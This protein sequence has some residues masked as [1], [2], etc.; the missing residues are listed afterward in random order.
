MSNEINYQA[1]ELSIEELDVVAGGA[2][3][4]QLLVKDFDASFEQASVKD[5]RAINVGPNGVQAVE[6]TQIDQTKTVA[7]N[8]VLALIG[9]F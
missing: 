2:G 9:D 8:D 3:L 7:S 1:Q 6:A 4:D 5:V